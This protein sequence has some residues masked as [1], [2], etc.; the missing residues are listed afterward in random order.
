MRNLL[1]MLFLVFSF[2]YK[3][4]AF[5]VHPHIS[6]MPNT[7]TATVV[8]HF[9]RPMVCSGTAYGRTFYG[10]VFN[11]WM[12]SRVIWPG[13]YAHVYVYTNYYDRFANGWAHINCHWYY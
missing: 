3:A 9:G 7:V 11:A 10:N 6:V 5:V 2:S 13:Q 1:I 4:H 8:N 12:Y